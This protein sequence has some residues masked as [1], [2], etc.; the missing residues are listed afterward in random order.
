MIDAWAS[1]KSFRPKE[2]TDPDNRD[3]DGDS[4][5]GGRDACRDWRGE[6]RTNGPHVSTA[7]LDARLYKKAPGQSEARDRPSSS[8]MARWRSRWTSNTAM[9]PSSVPNA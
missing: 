4:D 1:M 2:E 6:R 9:T 7:D 5:G 8:T 3:G